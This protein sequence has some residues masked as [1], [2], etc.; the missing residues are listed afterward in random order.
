MNK[1]E[2]LEDA[3]RR[4]QKIEAR[5]VINNFYHLTPYENTQQILEEG[6]KA[7]S[8]GNIFTFT[9]LMVANTI[10]KEQVFTDRYSIFRI[11]RE[12][13]KGKPMLDE[14]GEFTAPYHRIIK[15][16][17]IKPKYLEFICEQETIYDKPT[18]WDYLLYV[19]RLGHTREQV[20]ERFE[21]IGKL[22]EE[23]LRGKSMDELINE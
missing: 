3:I 6:I 17:H 14:V 1:P 9:D 16:P 2:A 10:A 4:T 18:E 13:F 11:I 23:Y 20:D 7:D 22:R 15:Y 12:G 8:E 21:M 19:G 5:R